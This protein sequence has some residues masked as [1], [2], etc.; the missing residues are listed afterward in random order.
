MESL[1]GIKSRLKAVKS[2]GQITKAMEVVSAT[3]MRK[4]QEIALATRP[5]AF[6]ALR[7]LAK[8]SRHVSDEMLYTK[9][10]P[11]ER[12]LLIVIASDKGLAGSFNA[13]VFRMA[14]TFLTREQSEGRFVGIIAVGKRAIQYA[15]RKG[16]E[17]VGEFSGFGDYATLVAV[18]P[19]VQRVTS[20]FE[21]GTYDQVIAISAHFRTAL[22]QETLTRHILPIDASHI[23]ETI[24]EIVP[25]HG[26][27]SGQTSFQ[28]PTELDRE[29]DYIF[30]PSAKEVFENLLPHLVRM[31]IFHIM[32][33]ANASEHSARRVAMKTASDNAEDLTESLSLI[34]NKARQANITRELIEI[35]S[36]QNALS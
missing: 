18:E 1:Q 22:K 16:V 12:T 4:A 20:T 23:I 2:V 26:R 35:T 29:I 36:T 10:R 6:E 8:L 31:Q 13:Q 27:F 5:Y 24:R 11:V 28:I 15:Q 17:I 25:A 19:F 21:E 7:L 34:F 30:E 3:K 9:K 14:D 32:L 33:E